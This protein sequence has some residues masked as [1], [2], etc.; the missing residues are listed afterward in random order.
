ADEV[1]DEFQGLQ[2]L[3]VGPG[4]VAEDGGLLADRGDHAVAVGAVAR[5]IEGAAVLGHVDEMPAGRAAPQLRAA[6]AQVVCQLATSAIDEAPSSA[7]R[8][9]TS[10]RACGSRWGSARS[11]T[12]RWP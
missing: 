12:R 11:A 8:R 3:G 10:A 9:C 6:A 2:A 7:S 5:G 4:A 1:D